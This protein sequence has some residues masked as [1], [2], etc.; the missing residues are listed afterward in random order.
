[1]KSLR[2]KN[3][4]L[5]SRNAPG[6]ARRASHTLVES[7]EQRRL[8]SAA[9]SL[10]VA[11][12]TITEGHAGSQQALVVVRLSTAATQPVTVNFRTADGTAAAGADYQSVSG[13]LTFAA[14][15]TVRT[16]AVPITGDR[17][18][19]PDERFTVRLSGAKNATIGDGTGLVTV[20]D[21]EPR[22][23]I[24]D[25][26]QV[27]G[28]A[29]ESLFAFTVRL[30]AASD[31]AVTVDYTT[32]DGTATAADSDYVASAGTLTFAPGETTKTVLT[33]VPGDT[34]SEPDEAFVL[35]LGGTANAFLAD[36]QAVGRILT[37]DPWTI[38]PDPQEPCTQ[39]CGVD[40]DGGW[41][42]VA[43]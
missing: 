30:S 38:E 25:V 10:S 26:G 23:T 8:L 29:G 9:P 35:N 3:C 12:L 37:N 13:K 27:E 5:N 15:Q 31:L 6:V 41:P 34:T 40:A 14:G 24:D 43:P 7:L 28:D 11:D 17:L 33:A 1:M 19:E 18:G 20:L 36:P 21:D 39:N 32:A 42:G 16:I 2:L 22:V 4:S